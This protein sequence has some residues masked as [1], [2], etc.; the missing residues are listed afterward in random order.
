[1][2]RSWAKVAA[3]ATATIGTA[4]TAPMIQ[5]STVPDATD[6]ATTTG[7]S[8]T[9]R[10]MINGCSTWPSMLS[11]HHDQHEHGQRRQR[12]APGQR[13]QRRDPHGDGRTDQRHERAEQHEQAERQRQRTF[14]RCNAMPTKVAF[15]TATSTTPRV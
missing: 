10:L 13:H 3:H 15:D 5:A 14:S 7:C 8:F 9:A 4:T 6:T 2:A 1:M 11:D 12:T